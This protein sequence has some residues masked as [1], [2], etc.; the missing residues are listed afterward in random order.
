MKPLHNTILA[1]ALL[2]G[3]YTASG[4]EEVLNVITV[5]SSAIT[6][7]AISATES[8]SVSIVDEETMEI[9][10][11][12][13]LVEVLKTVPGM[14]SVARAGEMLQFRVRGVGQQQYMGEK[15]GVAI[16]I[17]GV[18]VMSQAGGIT[19]NLTDIESVKVIKGSASYLY[20][21]TALAGAIVI[22]TKQPKNKS[23]NSVRAEW[24]SYGY[25]EYIVGTNQATDAFALN[26]NAAYRYTSG[27][28]VDSELWTKSLNG[29]FAYYIDDS[30]DITLG[31]DIT[32]KF[33]E[34]GSRSVVSGET[35]AILNP[36]G[37][38]NSGYTKDSGVDLDKYF[39]TY[40]KAFGNDSRIKVTGYYYDDFYEQTS[41]PQDTDGNPA[42]PDVYVKESSTDLTQQG[43]KAEYTYEGASVGSLLGAEF[44]EREYISSSKTLADYS[45]YNFRTASMENYYA[46]E[47]SDTNSK[48]RISALYG[49]LK[50][51]L[52]QRLTTTL[53]ARY[54][55]QKKEYVTDSFDF[56]GVTWSNNRVSQSRTFKNSAYRA[57]GT[58][59][60]A[61]DTHL[62]ANVATGYET[63]D[64]TDLE[65]T[66]YLKDQTSITYEAGVRGTASA[67]G[68]L[69]Y[70]LSLYQMDNKDILGPVGG[71][72]SFSDPMDN[73]GDSRHRGIELSLNS[74]HA[75]SFAFDLAYTYLDAQY[76]KHNPFTVQTDY[77][78]TSVVTTYDIS[79]NEIPRVS[80]HTMDLFLHYRA[81]SQLTFISEIYARSSYWADETN[82]IK[83]DGYELLNLQARYMTKLGGNPLELFAKVDNLFDN[84]YYRAAFIHRDKR[85]PVG[86]DRDD[87][88]ITVDPGRVFYAGL[89]YLF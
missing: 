80:K 43:V 54:N 3:S 34:G 7:N 64:V 20:G 41:N 85:A 12:K 88:S 30:S 4:A 23:E 47:T 66:P 8:S 32:D 18:P 39:L 63:P 77:T 42:T 9:V 46:G 73:I 61:T 19:L 52:T 49:E 51:S 1:A 28:W 68:G 53:N 13:N 74:D 81:T 29:K 22:T 48:E 83:M 55:V 50:Y 27:Y 79:K 58:Y 45:S 65:Q 59:R 24:G 31:V 71:T 62:F 44:G 5:E 16:I 38:A 60:V 40:T 21:D 86:I 2:A 75:K 72:Y 78:N 36:K 56:D 14:T 26:L 67:A 37:V 76:T 6:G 84:Q 69:T 15:P 35:E 17:D 87:L 57:G 11:P 10:G 70:E 82:L 25:Q 33:D 89:K